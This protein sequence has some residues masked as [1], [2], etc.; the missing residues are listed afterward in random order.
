MAFVK[1]SLNALAAACR[2]GWRFDSKLRSIFE[3]GSHL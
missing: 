1:V 2:Q 3:S